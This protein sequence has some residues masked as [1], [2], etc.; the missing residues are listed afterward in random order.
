METFIEIQKGL[1]GGEV[2][3]LATAYRIFGDEV[4]ISWNVAVK[5]DEPLSATGEGMLKL[6]PSV[7]LLIVTKWMGAVSGVPKDSSEPSPSGSMSEAEL[8]MTALP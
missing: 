5:A 6:P 2:V 3:E 7:E 1:M 8:E 4:L